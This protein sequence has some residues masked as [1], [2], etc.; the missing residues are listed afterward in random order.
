VLTGRTGIV[1][2]DNA[3]RQCDSRAGH[4]KDELDKLLY[5][6]QRSHDPFHTTIVFCNGFLHQSK[7]RSARD[8]P[9]REDRDRLCTRAGESRHTCEIGEGLATARSRLDSQCDFSFRGDV[10]FGGQVPCLRSAQQRGTWAKAVYGY[11]SYGCCKR[12]PVRSCQCR[13]STFNSLLYCGVTTRNRNFLSDRFRVEVDES[14]AGEG[15]MGA[16][17]CQDLTFV[18]AAPFGVGPGIGVVAH[19]YP[20]EAVLCAVAT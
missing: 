1:P 6:F 18:A 20:T 16:A 9:R 7:R 14:C 19:I 2:G 13:V 3:L 15:E 5:A 10:S 12:R 17:A 11:G 8:G 4:Q